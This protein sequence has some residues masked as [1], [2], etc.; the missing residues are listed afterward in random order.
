MEKASVYCGEHKKHINVGKMRSS[1]N[2]KAG[3]KL[4]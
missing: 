3:G 1:F 4:Y 2:D